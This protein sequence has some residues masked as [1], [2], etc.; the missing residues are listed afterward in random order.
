MAVKEYEATNF[1]YS[2]SFVDEQVAYAR[3][4]LEPSDDEVF[5]WR[6]ASANRLQE[7][8]YLTAPH[9][10]IVTIHRHYIAV[11]MPIHYDIPNPL[12]YFG[13]FRLTYKY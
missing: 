11:L 1:L 3:Y 7:V 5:A 6:I 8:L 13:R 2:K 9:S 10:K 4:I 12:F